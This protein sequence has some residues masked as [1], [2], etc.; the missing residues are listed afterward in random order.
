M[1]DATHP[2]ARSVIA[3]LA[4]AHRWAKYHGDRAAQAEAKLAEA[5]AAF[6]AMHEGAR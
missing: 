1:A 6:D 4:A 2:T 3:R 5:R